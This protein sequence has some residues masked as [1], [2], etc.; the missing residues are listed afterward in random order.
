MISPIL[1]PINDQ[2]RTPLY[3]RLAKLIAQSSLESR[4]RIPQSIIDAKR[5]RKRPGFFLFDVFQENQTNTL[6]K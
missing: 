3:E 1:A 6:Q 2:M 5:Q 4:T